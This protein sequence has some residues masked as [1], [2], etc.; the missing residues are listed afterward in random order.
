[1]LRICTVLLLSG[2]YMS[3]FSFRTS[4][5]RTKTFPHTHLPKPLIGV[6]L[7]QVQ[8]IRSIRIRVVSTL[9]NGDRME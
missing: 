4:I 6:I 2:H 1:M 7:R 3:N 8:T 5:L 9:K